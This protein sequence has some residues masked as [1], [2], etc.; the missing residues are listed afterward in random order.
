MRISVEPLI[1]CI[2]ILGISRSS[3]V[4]LK[5]CIELLFGIDVL[6]EIKSMHQHDIL[7]KITSF[8]GI[9]RRCLG[10]YKGK[11]AVKEFVT[12]QKSLT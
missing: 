11:N 8:Y 6:N 1:D 2:L 10:K 3:P 9:V 7:N 12:L 5:A 4:L